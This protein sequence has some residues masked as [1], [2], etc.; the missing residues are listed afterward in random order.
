MRC[1][2]GSLPAIA[3]ATLLGACDPSGAGA[4]ARER[5]ATGDVASS[6][7]V[8][9]DAG[10]SLAVG[11]PRTR[12]VSMIPSVTDLVI[13]LGVGEVLV[14]RTR[15]DAHPETEH[16]PSVGGGLDPDL[17]TLLGLGP[18]LVVLWPDHDLRGVGA[19]LRDLGIPTYSARIDGLAEFRR[20]GAAV[21][22]L[23]GVAERVDS[24]LSAL[25]SELADVRRAVDGL[26]APAVVYVVALNP[27]TIA[28]P[29]T[30]VDSL[31][32]TA[33]GRN[34][35]ADVGGPWPQ[36]SL[37][38]VVRR[39]PDFVAV[40]VSDPGALGT[41]AAAPG[42]RT[43]PAVLDGRTIILDP[44]R[45]NR[46]GPGIAQAAWELATWLHPGAGAA[47]RP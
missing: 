26:P 38:E 6:A 39:S 28:G 10:D 44:D 42:W 11:A 46:P 17:E 13:E 21:G 25:D 12:I 29:G 18:D 5:P 27:P 30:F 35:F 23:L 19:R 9:D 32:T 47:P 15:Y 40:S 4:G 16:L 31:V 22:R 1:V 36:V 7:F 24:L 43:L 14:G 8:V 3:A 34:A 41:L 20:H 45:F 33:G 2:L 37:E